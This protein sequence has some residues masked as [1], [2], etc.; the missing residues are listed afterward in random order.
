VEKIV[1]VCGLRCDECPAY[2]ATVS[3]DDA[4]REET[5]R[6]WSKAYNSDISP[7]D[8]NCM[9]CLSREGPHFS[10]CYE[11]EIRKC[12]TAR[13]VENCAYCEDYACDKVGGLFEMVPAARE[14]L[15]AI[16]LGLGGTD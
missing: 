7:G 11:C 4:K 5:A 16:R 2:I 1:A 15:D 13:G 9:S 8:I 12:A 6:Q 14:T 10:H 3:D